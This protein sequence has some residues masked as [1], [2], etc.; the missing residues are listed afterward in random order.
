MFRS[1]SSAI[2]EMSK[3]EKA[4]GLV[5][6]AAWN[7]VVFWFHCRNREN[8]VKEKDDWVRDLWR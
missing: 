5:G 4:A 2:A 8:E 6:R 3:N 7:N 1:R